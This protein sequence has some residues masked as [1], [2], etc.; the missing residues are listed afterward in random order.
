M[1]ADLVLDNARI[2]TE[3]GVVEGAV[4][5]EG[6]TVVAITRPG[7]DHEPA[8]WIDCEGKV[9]LPGLVDPHVHMGGGAPYEELCASES[10]SA[11][12]GGVT[13]MLQY[14]RSMTSFL[15]SFPAEREVAE[16]I[17]G[18][19]TAFHFIL[20]G[21][22][23]TELIPRY[24]GAWG[25]T[26]FK[27][28][29]GG[30]SP[31]NRIGLVTVSDAVLY[32]AMQLIRDLGPHGYCMVHCEDDS[33]VAFLTEKAKASGEDDLVA[34]SASRPAFVEE[35][36]VRRAI[37]LAE[38]TGSPLYIPHTTIGSAISSAA[39]A[40]LRGHR[41]L[42]ETCPHYLALTADDERLVAQGAGMGKVS[43]AL[44]GTEDQDALWWGLRE[45]YVHTVGSDHVPILKTGA[46][47]WDEWPGFAGLATMLPVLVTEGFLKGRIDLPKLAQVTSANPA[48]TFGLYPQKGTIAVGSDADLVVVDL[49][50]EATVGPE[51]TRS[52]YTSAFEDLPLRGWPVLT[53]RRGDIIFEDGAYTAPEGS[54]RIV[55]PQ[56]SR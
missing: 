40:R 54:G 2:V 55:G 52:R 28:Y 45:G 4:V 15:D 33:L 12:R 43:P 21:M 51:T 26:S 6:E 34:Y 10:E 31:G 38:L 27:F 29:M 11:A 47:L 24:A 1:T 44:R 30:Y 56:A 18:V 17:M 50:R 39:E 16:R 13:T 36:D 49:D 35:Q 25:V 19:D 14:R 37:C 23:Q 8:R 46:P 32:R 5:V 41:V 53:V 3:G 22:E 9:V 7:T 20:D 42:L 48:R